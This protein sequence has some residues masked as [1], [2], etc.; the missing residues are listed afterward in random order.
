MIYIILILSIIFNVYLYKQYFES[1]I[2]LNDAASFYL[3]FKETQEER[4][5]LIV[6]KY[7]VYGYNYALMDYLSHTYNFYEED[8]IIKTLK[9]IEVTQN[10][11]L[12]YDYELK[13][14]K[15]ETKGVSD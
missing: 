6:Q 5:K 12:N 8:K 2:A 13:T 7:S 9:Q 3:E 4:D 1:I 10:A 11:I 15:D 14:K